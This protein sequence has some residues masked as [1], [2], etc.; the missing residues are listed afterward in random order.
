MKTLLITILAGGILLTSSSQAQVTESDLET[1]L[2]KTKEIMNTSR[3]FDLKPYCTKSLK[4]QVRKGEFTTPDE[5]IGFFDADI[6]YD[7]QDDIPR[8]LQMGPAKSNGELVEVPVLLKFNYAKSDDEAFTKRWIFLKENNQWK[9][10]DLE[11]IKKGQI[12]PASLYRELLQYTPPKTYYTSRKH[13]SDTV[14]IRS[15][16][17]LV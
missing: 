11:T 12:R 5:P 6:R 16:R 3:S 15:N 2:Q 13:L 7:T 10:D 4:K 8:I 14:E 1:C 17:A 9:V